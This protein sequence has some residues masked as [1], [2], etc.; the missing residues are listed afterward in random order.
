MVDEQVNRNRK[1]ITWTIRSVSPAG[2]HDDL[3]VVQED[4][5]A[6]LKLHTE[7]HLDRKRAGRFQI[8]TQL[9][10]LTFT[11]PALVTSYFT[12]PW[13]FIYLF[14]IT[15]SFSSEVIVWLQL[16]RC[17]FVVFPLNHLN[18]SVITLRFGPNKHR[19]AVRLIVSTRQSDNQRIKISRWSRKKRVISVS[20]NKQKIV[21]SWRKSSFNESQ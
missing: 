13:L 4:R 5:T 17:F 8:K 19:E 1:Y 2:R 10:I 12:D 9:Q 15:R 16:H 18:I 6:E 11:P 14:I 20:R 21:H 7:R 3:H